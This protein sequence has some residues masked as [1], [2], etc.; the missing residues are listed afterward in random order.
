MGKIFEIDGKLFTV[1][2]KIADMVLLNILWLLCCIPVITAGAATTA[3]YDISLKMA[4]NRESY[5]FSSYLKSFR[6]NFRQSTQVWGVILISVTVLYFDIYFSAH[7]QQRFGKIL[8]ILFAAAVF[9]LLLMACY[10]FPVLAVFR[11]TTKKAMK[12]AVLMA[13]AHL[14]YTL[15]IVLIDLL[16][17]WLLFA[18]GPVLGTFIDVVI[19]FAFS[20][21]VNAHIFRKVFRKYGYEPM[22][23]T[24][25]LDGGF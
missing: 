24:R 21:W 14:L 25:V 18:A 19:G 17:F 5:V 1:M 8:I 20:A 2:S 15:P 12:N 22:A 23:A 10:V 13:A 4:D 6:E 7:T 16:P 11:N 9:L 3:L